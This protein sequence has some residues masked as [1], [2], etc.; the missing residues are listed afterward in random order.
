MSNQE[1]DTDDPSETVESFTKV[2]EMPSEASVCEETFVTEDIE[3]ESEIQERSQKKS[4]GL[5]KSECSSPF[6][7][8]AFIYKNPYYWEILK[9]TIIFLIALKMARE[10]K[11][12]R[13]PLREYRP[14]NK[15]HF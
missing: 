4:T 15:Y 5:R 10:C 7:Y 3:S 13:I 2:E 9:S 6:E 1:N 8:V 11:M 14:F 12:L